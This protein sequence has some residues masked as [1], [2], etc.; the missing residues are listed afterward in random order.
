MGWHIAWYVACIGI[1]D[2]PGVCV[3]DSQVCCLLRRARIGHIFFVL[4]EV[5]SAM[6][7]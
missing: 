3:E 6:R 5:S 1:W 2:S 7:W 4:V